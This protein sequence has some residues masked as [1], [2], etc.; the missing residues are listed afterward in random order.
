M[1]QAFTARQ[2]LGR[3]AEFL[4][5]SDVNAGHKAAALHAAAHLR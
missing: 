2:T 4:L 3:G 1:N 5:C